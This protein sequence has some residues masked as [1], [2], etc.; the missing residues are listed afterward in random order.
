LSGRLNEEIRAAL[1]AKTLEDLARSG[2]RTNLAFD[3]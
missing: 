1:A 3:I 2:G